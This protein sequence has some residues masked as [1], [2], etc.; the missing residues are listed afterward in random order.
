MIDVKIEKLSTLRYT[1]L[2]RAQ[3]FEGQG[4]TARVRLR[5]PKAYPAGS[6]SLQEQ[7]WEGDTAFGDKVEAGDGKQQPKLKRVK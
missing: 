6:D 1:S 5:L 4:G 2:A 7:A 3:P